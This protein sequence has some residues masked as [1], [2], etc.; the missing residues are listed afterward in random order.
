MYIHVCIIIQNLVQLTFALLFTDS[1]L[2]FAI[3]SVVVLVAI[4]CVLLL[5]VVLR[6]RY[7]SR[8]NVRQFVWYSI[9]LKILCFS[10]AGKPASFLCGAGKRQ[11]VYE[12]NTTLKWGHLEVKW[13]L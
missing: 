8:Y 4:A 5:I 6:C 2:H 11:S 9:S 10:Y 1:V 7:T 13:N 3:P 12:I